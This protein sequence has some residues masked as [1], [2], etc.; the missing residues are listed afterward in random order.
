MHGPCVLISLVFSDLSA[1]SLVN[2]STAKS[3]PHNTVHFLETDSWSAP[4]KLSRIDN[5]VQF[6]Y[7]RAWPFPS[8]FFKKKKHFSVTLTHPLANLSSINLVSIFRC[9]SPPR[10]PVYVRRVDPSDLDFSL[11]GDLTPTPICKSS[12]YLT[13]SRLII[14][15]PLTLFLTVNTTLRV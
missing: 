10:N 7:P 6:L 1:I 4:A 13:I 3:L 14:S 9:S 5:I 11:S 12:I 8:P 15:N 2:L